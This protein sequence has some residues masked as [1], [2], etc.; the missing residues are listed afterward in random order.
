MVIVGSL[1]DELR[2]NLF[3]TDSKGKKI[4]VLGVHVV[5]VVVQQKKIKI[6]ANY[7]IYDNEWKWQIKKYYNSHIALLCWDC[8]VHLRR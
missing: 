6:K 1:H 5:L 4:H 2:R 8:S 7:Q 3:K